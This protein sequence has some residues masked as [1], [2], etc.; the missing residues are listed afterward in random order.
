[1]KTTIER[2]SEAILKRL[3]VNA[4]DFGRSFGINRGIITAHECGI[5]SSASLMV[6]WNAAAEAAHYGREHRRLGLGLHFDA[7]EWVYC[8][9]TWTP[10]YTVVD[11][12]DRGAIEAELGRQLDAFRALVGRPPSHLDSHQ[13]VHLKEPARS[14]LTEAA[15]ALG[16]TLRGCEPAVHYR[17]DFYGQDRRGEPLPDS[18]SVERLLAILATLPPGVTEVGCHPGEAFDL[19]TDYRDERAEEVKVLCDPR[20]RRALVASGITL[21]SFAVPCAGRPEG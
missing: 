8:A 17:G 11:L 20:V 1:M 14:V 6:R 9:E 2:P 3:I 12:A 16:V 7:G 21:G 13:H 5:V 4:D 15:R 10:V 19:D 18:I